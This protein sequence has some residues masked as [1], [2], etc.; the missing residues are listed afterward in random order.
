MDHGAPTT[1]DLRTFGLILACILAVFGGLAWRKGG[2]AAPYWLAAA[3][4][5]AAVS[6]ARPDAMIHVF[7]PWMRVAMAIAAVNTFVILGALYYLVFTPVARVAKLFG[8]DFLDLS[9][10]S[11]DSYWRPKADKPDYDRQF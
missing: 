8:E 5:S 9:L 6:L 7:R 4:L 3:A 10:E 2:A 11:A 1:K